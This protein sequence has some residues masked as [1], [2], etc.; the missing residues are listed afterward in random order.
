MISALRKC[1]WRFAFLCRPLI[2]MIKQLTAAPFWRTNRTCNLSDTELA[3]QH[4]VRS[5]DDVQNHL[6]ICNEN[7][8]ST[9]ESLM[10]VKLISPLIFAL[11]SSRSL[12]ETTLIWSHSSLMA[13]HCGAQGLRAIFFSPLQYILYSIWGL[14]HHKGWAYIS[15]G[16]LFFSSIMNSKCIT[17][18]TWA[19]SS[20]IMCWHSYLR[21]EENVWTDIKSVFVCVF[22]SVCRHP[23]DQ[24][25]GCSLEMLCERERSTV[26]RFVRLCTEAVEKRGTVKHTA[27]PLLMWFPA[28]CRHVREAAQLCDINHPTKT[29]RETFVIGPQSELK[30]KTKNAQSRS[31]DSCQTKEI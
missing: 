7:S 6:W 22:V 19:W 17:R 21:E 1:L 8:E 23:S 30:K 16:F 26:P 24:V 25:F 9:I 29:Y 14:L 27:A 20:Y 2:C 3:R 11:S 15:S 10:I 13:S 18:L 28:Y 12:S 31:C 5:E 4:F